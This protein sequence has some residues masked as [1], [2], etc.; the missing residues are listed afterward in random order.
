MKGSSLVEGIT[1]YSTF[2]LG[3]MFFLYKKT[4]NQTKPK[5]EQKTTFT[6]VKPNF[7]KKIMSVKNAFQLGFDGNF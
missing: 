5:Q 4:E 3:S 7:K 6:E 2:H 1:T